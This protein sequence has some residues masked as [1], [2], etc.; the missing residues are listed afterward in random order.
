MTRMTSDINQVQT[1]V[2]MFLRLFMRSPFI[3]FGSMLMAFNVDVKAAW[4]LSLPFLCLFLS[5]SVS[6]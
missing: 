5:C 2:N 4:S 1:V 6:F 3:V